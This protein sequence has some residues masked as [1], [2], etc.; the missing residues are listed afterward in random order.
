MAKWKGK[1][2]NKHKLSAKDRK[3]GGQTSSPAKAFAS[4]FK[5][6]LY[7]DSGCPVYP[8]PYEPFCWKPEHIVKVRGRVKRKCIVRATMP[9]ETQRRMLKI[10]QPSEK[11]FMRVLTELL[12]ELNVEVAKDKNIDTLEKMIANTI[13][14][15]DTFWGKK[16]KQEISGSLDTSQRVYDAPE[17]KRKMEELYG[18]K[19]KNEGVRD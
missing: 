17:L 3:K 8:C 7:C 1:E 4:A 10:M 15:H 6:R 9:A 16:T 13:K 14:I 18:D 5:T 19:K 2:E 11:N 12:T